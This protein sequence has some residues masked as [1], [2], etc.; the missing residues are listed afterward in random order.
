VGIGTAHFGAGFGGCEHP[1]DAGRSGVSLSFPRAKAVE[2]RKV[3]REI[4]AILMK[5]AAEEANGKSS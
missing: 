4:G 2:E 5:F 3:L 1:F